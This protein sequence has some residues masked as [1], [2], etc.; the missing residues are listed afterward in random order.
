MFATKEEQLGLLLGHIAD[1]LD[2][3]HVLD[4]ELTETYRHL[5]EWIKQ[6]SEDR[7]DA[8]A[9]IYPQGSRLLG[10]LTQPVDP[11]EDID[12]DLVYL[13]HIQR[14]SIDKQSLK[15]ETGE[16][17]KR[18]VRHLQQSG[19]P[20][21]TL[22]EGSRCW[23]LQYGKK[24]HLD[25]LPA[26][27]DDQVDLARM[28]YPEHAIIITDRDLYRW[29]SSNPRG[30]A[31][32]FRSRME[33]AFFEERLLMAKSAN[34]D[35]EEIPEELVR[36]PLQRVVQ[37]LKRHRDLRYQD[38]PADK[39]ISIIITTL[40][41]RACENQTD[42]YA[43][44]HAVASD[45]TSY[46]ENRNGVYWIENPVNKSENFADKWEAH[47]VRALRF[48]E[49]VEALRSDLRTALQKTGLD[50]VANALGAS[51]GESVAKSA[52]KRFGESMNTARVEKK[53]RVDLPKLT[54]GA[55]GGVSLRDHTFF[56]ETS[57]S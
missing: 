5:G 25:V 29:Q 32:W 33:S 2:V 15:S 28:K 45:M 55:V 50:S 38:D 37:L 21:P 6:D 26:L 24:Y 7:Y 39:P 14:N 57:E 1:S 8:D 20:V 35:V 31:K 3:P 40:A 34:V 48:R 49:W 51:F 43:A 56:G 22:I 46:I 30:Y 54:L 36:T 18:Y 16:Q 42:V 23:T 41:T 27:P 4:S 11:D 12:I 47:P 44:L 13:R 19:R 9:E 52:M 10:T 53:L 17:L